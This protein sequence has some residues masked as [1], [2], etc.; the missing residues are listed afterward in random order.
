[1]T[2]DNVT[3]QLKAFFIPATNPL[4]DTRGRDISE[5]GKTWITIFK[6]TISTDELVSSIISQFRDYGPYAL[7]YAYSLLLKAGTQSINISELY[8]DILGMRLSANEKFFIYYQLKSINFQGINSTASGKSITLYQ[9]II[10]EFNNQLKAKINYIPA[11]E[12]NED[13]IVVF[14]AQFLG[15]NHAPT[16]T[17]LDRIRVLKS[18]AS[19]EVILINTCDLL[20]KAGA[21][22][23]FDMALAN[24]ADIEQ[25]TMEYQ[26]AKFKYAQCSDT[27]PNV[28]EMTMLIDVINTLK[29]S[30]TI[31]IGENLLADISS[32]IVPNAVISTVFSSL[33]YSPSQFRVIG[34]KV[35]ELEKNNLSKYGL[36]ADSVIESTF[37]FDFK[38]QKNIFSRSSLRLPENKL[39]ITL[40][41]GRLTTEFSESF[42]QEL[43]PLCDQGIHFVTVGYF[44]TY[45]QLCDKYPRFQQNSSHLGFQD[46]VLAVLETCD[47]FLNPPRAG[48]GSSAAEALFKG[49]P[50]ITL[51]MGDVATTAGQAF[52]VNNMHELREK[53]IKYKNDKNFYL[54]QSQIAKDRAKVLMN[55]DMAFSDVLQQI[56]LHHFF[57][58][59]WQL[60]K[61]M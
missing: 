5:L 30:F 22:P 58:Y 23:W 10:T 32:Q 26:G 56:N 54:E 21:L 49:K 20:P 25:Q 48:G 14:T 24:R 12:R 47:L 16:K 28:H 33:S 60:Y 43:L 52:I 13:V 46:D 41:G 11:T 19:K 4:Y 6:Q 27:M 36:S 50:V 42:L 9:Q 29:P 8:D 45:T 57:D 7:L 3:N 1:M 55:S 53:I 15:L 44:D 34:R 18:I 51:N 35:S 40:I 38:P 2:L 17:A 61:Q 31:S 37:T 39:L 59:P